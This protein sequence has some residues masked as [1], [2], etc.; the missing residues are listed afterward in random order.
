M[1]KKNNKRSKQ[2]IDDEDEEEE[3]DE[4][5]D[6]E[7]DEDDEEEEEEEEERP[8]KKSKSKVKAKVKKKK[9]PVEDDDDE[10]E[11]EEDED[12]EEDDDEEDEPPKKSKADKW[13][14]NDVSK[15]GSDR[16]G[17]RFKFSAD[18]EHEVIF[19]KDSGFAY[20]RHFVPSANKGQGGYFT[21]PTPGS[22]PICK[23]GNNASGAA[24][25]HVAILDDKKGKTFYT[26]VI[27]G[28]RFAKKFTK[29]KIKRG[30]LQGIV[31]AIT[32]TGSKMETDWDWEYKEKRKLTVEEKK[33]LNS[34]ADFSKLF[35]PKDEKELKT[36]AKSIN[37]DDEDDD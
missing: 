19:L 29:Q 24:A 32:K 31:F 26:T 7:E 10:D 18:E 9:K 12:E 21:C 36:V 11:E 23:A 5:L 30:T 13:F 14:S 3:D 34:L 1:A 4:D 17:D 16:K 25:F 6:D 15:M 22:C 35:R 27:E 28:A 33:M 2:E 20:Q 8:K 37:S